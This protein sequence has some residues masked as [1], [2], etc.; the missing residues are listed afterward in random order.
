MLDRCLH[1]CY[2][3]SLIYLVQL[4]MTRLPNCKVEERKD[5]GALPLFAPHLSGLPPALVITAEVLPLKMLTL[6]T[7]HTMMMDL[8]F[9][10]NFMLQ[11]WHNSIRGF[12]SPEHGEAKWDF[13]HHQSQCRARNVIKKWRRKL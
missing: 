8:K 6:A 1:S 10:K 7:Y 4:L 3:A 2:A 12:P 13:S 5:W 11:I 9:A